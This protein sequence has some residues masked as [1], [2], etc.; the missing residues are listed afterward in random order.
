LVICGETGFTGLYDPSTFLV[1]TASVVTP[2]DAGEHF[3]TEVVTL[4]DQSGDVPDFCGNDVAILILSETIASVTPLEP[5]LDDAPAMSGEL[6]SAV[7]YGAINGAGD[8]S[9]TRRRLDGIA[10][11]CV[12]TECDS[13]PAFGG[14]VRGNEW[15]GE[16]GVCQGDSGGPALDDQNRVF[17]VTSR[18]EPDCGATIYGYTVSRTQWLKD[19]T[20]YASGI[21]LY[22]APAW[23]AGS[24]VNPEHSMPIGD[25]C[26]SDD[27]CPAG[28]CVNQ[29]GNRFCS[30]ACTTEHPCPL[31]YACVADPAYGSVCLVDTDTPNVPVTGGTPPERGGGCALVADPARSGSSPWQACLALFGVAL[32][33][34][35][36]RRGAR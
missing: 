17:G 13:H 22:Q 1:T 18:G 20:V 35:C 8:E 29:E 15:V 7:G 28:K 6:F 2:E 31:D 4:P 5:R 34:L 19:V 30:R 26:S 36:R 33:L 14:T 12:S 21:G 24:S 10:V 11:E 23:T 16:G 25:A 27:D 3:V 9:G 32:G